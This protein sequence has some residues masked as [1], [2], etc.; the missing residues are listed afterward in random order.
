M[1]DTISNNI[2]PQERLQTTINNTHKKNHISKLLTQPHAV[3][4]SAL[5]ISNPICFNFVLNHIKVTTVLYSDLD[6][7]KSRLNNQTWFFTLLS[8]DLEPDITSKSKLS[9]NNHTRFTTLLSWYL[10]TEINSKSEISGFKKPKQMINIFSCHQLLYR[11]C[12]HHLMS[13]LRNIFTSASLNPV[14]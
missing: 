4:C 10:E 14:R 7:D 11:T 1:D 12:I 3:C 9:G 8:F 6:P 5:Y 2:K 13:R